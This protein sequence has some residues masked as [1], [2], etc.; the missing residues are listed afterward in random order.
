MERIN[1][2]CIELDHD[3]IYTSNFASCGV[4]RDAIS[5]AQY[6]PAWYQGARDPLLA[7]HPQLLRDF[8]SLR[9]TESRYCDEYYFQLD[10]LSENYSIMDLYER[11]RGKVLL[12]YERAT[13]LCHRF[14]FG[15]WMTYRIQNP[16]VT[17]K[18]WD[19]VPKEFMPKFKELTIYNDVWIPKDDPLPF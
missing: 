10:Q 8:Q 17:T 4:H 3:L 9:I 12:C 14:L 7:P 16:S 1:F 5:I 15:R 19:S 11:Y 13:S 2:N 6:S 18:D